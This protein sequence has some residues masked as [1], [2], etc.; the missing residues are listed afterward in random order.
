VNGG[1][2]RSEG[3]RVKPSAGASSER[4][5]ECRTHRSGGRGS[6][7]GSGWRE[8]VIQRFTHRQKRCVD[9]GTGAVKATGSYEESLSI[10]GIPDHHEASAFTGRRQRWSWRTPHLPT[11][12]QPTTFGRTARCS[13]GESR[14]GERVK[15]SLR[16]E[17]QRLDCI[18]TVGGK[19]PRSCP[20]R[21]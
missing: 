20:K 12:T 14:R 10:E 16:R 5:V 17:C 9:R 2:A 4:D 19:R 13:S 11:R 18:G 7:E 8:I 15:R 3:R 1:L 6:A 21:S